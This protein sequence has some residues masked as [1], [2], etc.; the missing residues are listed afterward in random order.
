MT[1]DITTDQSLHM[2]ASS[3]STLTLRC[4]TDM[5]QTIK[6]SYYSRRNLE[7]IPATIS[8]CNVSDG[9]FQLRTSVDCRTPGSSELRIFPIQ[10]NDSGL[11]ECMETK[12]AANYLIFNV[13]VVGM[14]H[15]TFMQ[16]C[17]FSH[18]LT[19]FA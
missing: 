6:W 7:D 3:Q 14:R 15:W 13:S 1:C 9:Q 16:L 12:K 11:Y 4:K 18:N 17:N 2:I 8:D 10:L 19:L 5:N